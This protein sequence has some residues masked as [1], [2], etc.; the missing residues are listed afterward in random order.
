MFRINQYCK[1]AY[2]SEHENVYALSQKRAFSNTKAHTTKGVST[3]CWY[4]YFSFQDSKAE[5][6]KLIAPFNG[7]ANSYKTKEE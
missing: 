3:K 5:K 4:V 2:A 6:L 7:N 1:F